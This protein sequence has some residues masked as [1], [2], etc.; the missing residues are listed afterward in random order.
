MPSSMIRAVSL[1]AAGAVLAMSAA[2]AN[3]MDVNAFT[4][5]LPL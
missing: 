1:V 3:K 4:P 5:L 2:D